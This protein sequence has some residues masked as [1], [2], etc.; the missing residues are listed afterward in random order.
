VRLLS[1]LVMQ[2]Q[3][4]A[5]L[6]PLDKQHNV[7]RTYWP[8]ASAESFQPATQGPHGLVSNLPLAA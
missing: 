4:G 5:L 1:N 3:P 6:G 2:V 8:L 7:F